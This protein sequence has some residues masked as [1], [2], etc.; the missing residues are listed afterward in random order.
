MFKKLFSVTAVAG[1]ALMSAGAAQ[2]APMTFKGENTNPGERV[3]G[4]PVEARA[5]FLANLSGVGTETFEGFSTGAT[6]PLAISFPGSGAAITGSITGNGAV[7]Q[8]PS[9]VGRFN[10]TG[11]TAAPVAGKWWNATNNFVLT[12]NK[13]ISAFGFYGTDIGDFDGQI[14]MALTDLAGVVTSMTIPN[15][16][17]APNA[18]LL[19]FGFV[20]LNNSYT[21]ISF[22]NTAAGEDQFGFDDFVVGERGQVIVPNPTP[23]P[24]T[25]GLVALSLLGLARASRRRT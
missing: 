22:G 7:I 20:D 25:L 19:F 17:N 3:F 5:A 18:S 11:A 8:T 1:A 10:T 14:T 16:K 6:G 9:T 2:A 15:T 24:A 23:E 4:A 13:A 12:F 21:K